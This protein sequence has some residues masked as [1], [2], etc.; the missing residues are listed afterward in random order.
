MQNVFQCFK[1]MIIWWRQ[2]QRVQRVRGHSRTISRNQFGEQHVSLLNYPFGIFSRLTLKS[3]QCINGFNQNHQTNI[4]S[5][6]S[7]PNRFLQ[8]LLL[9]IYCSR[10]DL[11]QSYKLV[12]IT[13]LDL[14]IPL[15]CYR[16]WHSLLDLCAVYVF[17]GRLT[18]HHN[19]VKSLKE[20]NCHCCL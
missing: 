12:G 19:P 14:G 17:K 20:A 15:K 1:Q 10:L 13:I 16:S 18:Y 5:S 3:S 6:K 2:V 7:D 4:M 9:I 11:I 8:A